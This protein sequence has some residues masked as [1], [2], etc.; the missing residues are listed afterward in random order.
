M[1]YAIGFTA[2]LEGEIIN[3]NFLVK[4]FSCKDELKVIAQKLI[5]EGRGADVPIEHIAI[6]SIF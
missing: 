3:G 5:K 6:I 2:P 4:N 1:S